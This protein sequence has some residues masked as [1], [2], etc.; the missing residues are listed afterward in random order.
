MQPQV[1]AD[2]RVRIRINSE[3]IHRRLG[4]RGKGV[5]EE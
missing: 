4:E 1:K 2:G 5:L 3:D